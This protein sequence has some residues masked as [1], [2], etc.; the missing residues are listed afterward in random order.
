MLMFTGF[1]KILIYLKNIN[2]KQLYSGVWRHLAW[3]IITNI[4]EELSASILTAAQYFT[5]VRT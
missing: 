4:S 5:V 1:M 3:L 2:L